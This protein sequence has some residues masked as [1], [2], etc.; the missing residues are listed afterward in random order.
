MT[1]SENILVYLLAKQATMKKRAIRKCAIA[2]AAHGKV[3]RTSVYAVLSHLKAFE[4]VATSAV[5]PRNV[6]VWLTAAGVAQAKH[7]R[8]TYDK[9][10]A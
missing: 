1:T 8:K 7:L 5:N 10:I 9:A 4:L 6:S 2:E 3:R